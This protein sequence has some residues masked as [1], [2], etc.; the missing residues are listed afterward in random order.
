MEAK[1][2]QSVAFKP[3][4]KRPEGPTPASTATSND[5]NNGGKESNPS[6]PAVPDAFLETW[7]DPFMELAPQSSCIDS[8]EPTL[9]DTARIVLASGDGKLRV[10]ANTRI[11][12]ERA[13]IG[14]PCGVLTLRP[15]RGDSQVVA[16]ASGTYVFVYRNLR[17]FYKYKLPET[18]VDPE[19]KEIWTSILAL[20]P[21]RACNLSD[22]SSGAGNGASRSVY[23]S[24]ASS[25]PVPQ[26]HGGD[27]SHAF[28]LARCLE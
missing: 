8:L 27:A 13:L 15:K 19:E 22:E 2:A 17:P 14:V 7:R 28:I 18:S 1:R 16:V 11:E 6:K 20:D 25:A 24:D 12:A 21:V 9:A 4:L 23:G 3:S 10:I 5:S 26:G